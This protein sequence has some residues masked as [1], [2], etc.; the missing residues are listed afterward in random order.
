MLKRI[1]DLLPQAVE[2]YTL[3]AHEN[4]AKQINNLDEEGKKQ[5]SLLRNRRRSDDQIEITHEETVGILSPLIEAF[6]YSARIPMF[7]RE[8]SLVYLISSFESFL[9]DIF[10]SI[11][12]RRPES[13]KSSQKTFTYTDVFGLN[14]LGELKDKLVDEEVRS[15][16]SQDI[17]KV[18]DKDLCQRFQLGLANHRKVSDWK[19]LKEAFYRRHI[20]IHNNYYPDSRYK[21]K[22]GFTGKEER[23]SIEKIYLERCFDIFERCSLKIKNSVLRKFRTKKMD[24][25]GRK[26]SATN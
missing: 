17:E 19:D 5:F 20:V 22:T 26:I 7:I 4:F 16:L 25:E 9:T 12:L 15:I 8:M 6:I 21:I 18:I 3:A 2:S 11:F 1:N 14:T 13:L 23:L 24:R 10:R